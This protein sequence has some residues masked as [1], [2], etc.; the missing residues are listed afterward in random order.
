MKITVVLL[1]MFRY[2][3]FKYSSLKIKVNNKHDFI[4]LF[5][6]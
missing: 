2:H 3:I 6:S 4:L 1:K 5:C